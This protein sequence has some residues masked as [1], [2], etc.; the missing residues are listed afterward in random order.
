[1]V[2]WA[3]QP[4]V[5][6]ETPWGEELESRNVVVE[7]RERICLRPIEEGDIWRTIAHHPR[8]TISDQRLPIRVLS[9]LRPSVTHRE[10]RRKKNAILPED[11]SPCFRGVEG[12]CEQRVLFRI[13][14][15]EHQNTPT[16]ELGLLLLI[17]K[18]ERRTPKRN[19][20][21]SIRESLPVNKFIGRG[22][23]PFL[24]VK[25]GGDVIDECCCFNRVNP[26][27]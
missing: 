26:H 12:I 4:C 8:R 2:L 16:L 15:K 7:R 20:D 5:L 21:R 3:R 22:P 23:Y 10:N 27:E 17:Q 6:G 1:M 19:H 24:R 13:M 9:S 18:N 14:H 11:H 25:S